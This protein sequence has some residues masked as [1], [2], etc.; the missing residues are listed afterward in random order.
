MGAFRCVASCFRAGYDF[1][2]W[3]YKASSDA[4][5][6]VKLPPSNLT[7]TLQAFKA[8]C[9]KAEKT[10]RERRGAGAKGGAASGSKKASGHF[11]TKQKIKNIIA[12]KRGGNQ[13]CP[14]RGGNQIY[15]T[16]GGNQI[17][18]TGGGNQI[19]PTGGRNQIY[20]TWGGNQIYPTW[21]GNQIYPSRIIL[22]KMGAC[23]K[24]FGKLLKIYRFYL[25]PNFL[26]WGQMG[27]EPD[28]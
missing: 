10:I 20:S 2:I 4:D 19:Y 3:F 22:E 14:T 6:P 5:P 18:P 13:I 9:I 21:S 7:E 8:N 24:P 1:L 26:A 12:V 23:A 11:K 15:P 16:G 25:D 17:Y 27:L 28:P